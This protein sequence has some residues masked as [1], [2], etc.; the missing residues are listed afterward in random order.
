MVPAAKRGSVGPMSSSRL[1]PGRVTQSLIRMGFGMPEAAGCARGGRGLAILLACLVL[2][3]PCAYAANPQPYEIAWVSCGDKTVDSTLKLTSQ[4]ETLRKS[5]PVDPFGLI[6][7]ARGDVARLQTVLQSFGYYDGSVTITIDGRGLDSIGLGNALS[8]LPKKSDAHVRIDPTLGPLFRIGRIEIKG[9]LPPGMRRK[10]P[11]ATGAPAVASDVLTA[12]SALQTALTDAGYA[13]AKV[14]KPL[15]YEEP[16]RHV[17]NLTFPVASGPRVRIGQIRIE[18]LKHV[19]E[20]LVRRRL[21]LQPG[22]RYDAATIEKAR[23]DLLTLG[24]FSTVSVAL[25]KPDAEERVPITF[26]VQEAKRYTVGV[27]AAYS[28]DL[29]GSGGVN[30]SDGDVFGGGQQLD[31]SATAINLGGTASTGLGYDAKL[32]YTIPDFRRRA[33]SL[34]LSV[35]ALRQELQ[36]YAEN[37]QI[38]GALLSRKLSSLWS[39]TAGVSYEHE[40]IGQPGATCP[41]PPGSVTNVSGISVCD[42]S[43]IRTYELLLLP[44]TALY[45]STELASPLQDPTH[46][47]RISLY[48]TPTFSYSSSGTVFLVTE[49]SLIHYLDLHELF[50][51]DPP[52]RTVFA[53]K[54]MVGL[55]EGAVWYNLPP[56]ERFYAGGSGTIRG[57]RYQSVGP[58]FQINGVPS[59]IP[60]GGT[61]I[62]VADLE[63]RQRVGT[64]FGFVV[65]ADGG[66]VSQ[67]AKPFS[68]TFRVGVGTGVRYYTSIGPIRFDVAFPT[69]RRASDDRFE[70]YIGLG[71]AF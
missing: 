59:G 70:I 53:T 13:F 4:L 16:A 27:S 9:A 39:A 18:G 54:F 44:M 68:G 11:L 22:E 58:Q 67:S 20:S 46:G 3:I 40:V 2:G 65:F 66:G 29:G 19:H 71:Q 36:A 42:Y 38:T 25:G 17:L 37:G 60:E 48:L 62:Q 30:W 64:N 21:L 34:S 5:A 33:Q 45:D 8:A 6:A 52:G 47:F 63:L 56:D 41:P 12:G 1:R 26:T 31:L 51:R 55:D 14:D 32:A 24:V 49:A 23:E 61:T 57:Y 7:R 35:E 28:S 43:Q 69:Q 15:A 10:L 50:A